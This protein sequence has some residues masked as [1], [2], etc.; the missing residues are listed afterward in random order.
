MLFADF[1]R[2]GTDNV[3]RLNKLSKNH[4][5]FIAHFVKQNPMQNIQKGKDETVLFTFSIFWWST[6]V[7][8]IKRLGH[9][10]WPSAVGVSRSFGVSF[11][12]SVFVLFVQFTCTTSFC[13]QFGQMMIWI[14]SCK[15]YKMGTVFFEGAMCH[16]I[17]NRNI[18]LYLCNTLWPFWR[19][20]TLYQGYYGD[21]N[22]SKLVKSVYHSFFFFLF[23][24]DKTSV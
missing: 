12:V 1:S 9:V 15:Q 11:F 19:H 3:I 23:E 5:L 8:L 10:E 20:Y 18:F 21:I 13:G 16:V 14:W 22:N 17:T 2:Q 4:T 6:R 24:E 7:F